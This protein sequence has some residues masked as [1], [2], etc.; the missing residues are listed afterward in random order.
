MVTWAQLICSAYR[1]IPRLRSQVTAYLRAP[2]FCASCVLSVECLVK[3]SPHAH[4][5]K[6]PLTREIRL[7]VSADSLLTVSRAMKLGPCHF[8]KVRCS[9]TLTNQYATS[10]NRVPRDTLH[11]RVHNR[12]RTTLL[13]IRWENACQ[14]NGEDFCFVFVSERPPRCVYKCNSVMKN[15]RT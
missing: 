1:R 13:S 7:P 5:P 9:H 11:T 15:R 3:W 10:I 6:F 12:S 4:K 14:I 8:N 2:N